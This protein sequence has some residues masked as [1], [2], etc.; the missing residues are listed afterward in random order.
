MI[1]SNQSLN[2]AKV[3]SLLCRLRKGL[4]RHVV[5]DILEASYCFVDVTRGEL[6]QLLVVTKDY[7]S[8]VD[9]AEDGQFMRLL[10]ETALALEKGA[11]SGISP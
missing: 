2:V 7:D 4:R 3:A 5:T 9:L 6:V 11:V 8:D 10:E 1:P